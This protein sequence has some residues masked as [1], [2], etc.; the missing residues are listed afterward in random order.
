MRDRKDNNGR[1]Y[2]QGSAGGRR[3]DAALER[4]E[5]IRAFDDADDLYRDDDRRD[6]RRN[7]DRYHDD[8]YD[9]R[10]DDRYYDDRRDG[11]RDDRYYDDRR[12]S[13]RDDRYHDDRRDDRRDD[14][15][16]DDRRDSRRDDRDRGGRRS[17]YREPPRWDDYRFD[18]EDEP[19]RERRDERRY[20]D[21]Q[22]DRRRDGGRAK[23]RGRKRR[24]GGDTERFVHQIVP[25]ALFWVGLFAAVSFVLRDIVGGSVGAFGSWLAEGLCALMGPMAYAIPFWFVLLSLRWKRFV[26][27]GILLK[28][29]FLSTVF[30][31]LLTGIIHVFQDGWEGSAV[32]NGAVSELYASGVALQ[33]GG[34]AGG[35]LGEW[36]GYLLY[37]VGT[38]LLA[39]PLLLIIGIYLIGMTPSG[40]WHR[41]AAKMKM[42]SARRDQ[43]RRE[44]YAEEE[45]R[46]VRLQEEKKAAEKRAAD[47]PAAKAEAPREQATDYTFGE[48][49]DEY[50]NTTRQEHQSKPKLEAEGK[51][52]EK[53]LSK[54]V[55]ERSES[56]S[57]EAELIDIPDDLPDIEEDTNERDLI[58]TRAGHTD[59]TEDKLDQILR[60]VSE[61]AAA[62]AEK[63][64]VANTEPLQSADTVVLDEIE[65]AEDPAEDRVLQGT[66]YSPFALHQNLEDRLAASQDA[67][68]QPVA[69]PLVQE[70]KSS[71]LTQEPL[72]SLHAEAQKE[73]E[74]P[75]VAQPVEEELAV[76]TVTPSVSEQPRVDPVFSKPLQ[77][78]IP[79]TVP[80]AS[81]MM[82]ADNDAVV[83]TAQPA[84]PAPAASLGGFD[85]DSG[86][87]DEPVVSAVQ[88]VAPV[89]QPVAPAVQPVVPTVQPVAPVAQPVA[90]VA[91]PITPVAQPAVQ[92]E[93][94]SFTRE[95]VAEQPRPVRSES[96]APAPA[97]RVIPVRQKPQV[98]T[99]TEPVKE[100]EK[101]APPPE[102]RPYRL[103]PISLLNE[104]KSIEIED[105]SEENQE[106]IDILRRTLE[107]F[108]VH[109]KDEVI[110][111]RGPTITRYEVRPEIGV[112][113][114]S[115]MNRIDDISLY[116][117]AQVRIA[118]IQGKAAVGVE[119]PNKK[120]ETVYL[121][122]LLESE[123]FKKSKNPVEVALGVGIG[124]NIQMCDL[125]AMPHLLVAG[126]TKSG[127]SVCIN[128]IILSLL[129]KTSPDDLR[130]ILID[131]KRVEF[132]P[133]MHLPHLYAPI[134]V[135]PA[136]AVGAL[137][138]AVQE[139]ERRYSLLEDVGARN[140]EGYN[141]KVKNDP[142]REH[143]PYLVIIIDE[144]YDLKMACPNNDLENHACR[145]A[146]KARAAGI[147]LIIGTQRPSV[148]V[149]TGTLKANIPSRIAFTVMQQV[150]SR[151]ILDAVG[152][153]LL[154]G[155]GDMLYAPMGEKPIRLQGS[156]V[157]DDEVES[158]V[159]FV[160]DR[161]DPVQY[162][163]AFMNQIEVEV[164]R[165]ANTG[166][167]NEDFDD[168]EDGEDGD[169]DPKF[170]DAVVLAVQSQKVATSL[171]Q[172]R[173]GVGYGRAA[174]II[175][176]MEELGLVSPAEG[177]KPRKL[178]DA[179]QSY[180]D[181]MASVNDDAEG[182]YGD[183]F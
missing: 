82:F 5:P 50:R 29:L 171:L 135:E 177:N 98:L 109:I 14:R 65:D 62:P 163:Q 182:D 70:E 48:D 79:N 103:P 168:F 46:A 42:A 96:V 87:E 118:P 73:P 159:S 99:R 55:E 112:P 31:W 2:G 155:R 145:L 169:E 176:R 104:D 52:A 107:S 47:A 97:D 131:P 67:P 63:E 64:P 20:D 126:A 100:E 119:V 134:I 95:I 175:D 114:R 150:D 18:D 3:E 180:L 162:N 74:Q 28:K 160:R 125:T 133:Y 21:R 137:A 127:K 174:K 12:D 75:A 32:L 158:V 72:G 111:S 167:K 139:M 151:T 77:Q 89:V 136:H 6:E 61:R 142:E 90:P 88:P 157:S 102:P 138:C 11:R 66:S 179:A 123:D 173:L 80:L 1:N 146:Q 156:F 147:H 23:H 39:I 130:L 106:K 117:E 71:H 49:E 94:V 122:T 16:Y 69:Q 17:A 120:R 124:G 105:H 45:R 140:F 27:E 35:F 56:T 33:S 53:E 152:A 93:S 83:I 19:R 170:F 166:K 76:R 181:H 172:R 10:R 43:R 113:V 165:A 15:Y 129:Y 132:K 153:E 108:N 161:N 141:E 4:G 13:R 91:Q 78:E 68:A 154:T 149:I 51:T 116:M 44:L 121:R 22:D 81:G 164:A 41:I 183:G 144:Y 25:Y 54:A 178:L 85:L 92:Q 115:I 30:L 34:V 143:L 7:G 84:A 8:R 148:N 36:M 37:P 24:I 101:A 58:L 59:S 128:T 57:K 60:E 40:I 86:E 26:R 110:C 9:S 38:G